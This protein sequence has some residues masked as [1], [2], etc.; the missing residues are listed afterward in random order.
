MQ[1]NINRKLLLKLVM[2]F[3]F[4]FGVY[5][6]FNKFNITNTKNNLD[7]K[8]VVNKSKNSIGYIVQKDVG[9]VANVFSWGFNRHIC[10]DDKSKIWWIFYYALDDT[11]K[12]G[13][14]VYKYSK[15]NGKTWSNQIK[16]SDLEKDAAD[17]TIDCSPPYIS[18]A[19]GDLG[20]STIYWKKGI[21]QNEKIHWT[22]SSVA[23]FD[24]RSYTHV[25]PSIVYWNGV[26][27]VSAHDQLESGIV[28]GHKRS[29]VTIAED[30]EGKK[31]KPEVKVFDGI[32]KKDQNTLAFT[33][34]AVAKN[35]LYALING[36]TAEMYISEYI[37]DNNWTEAKPIQ[38]FGYRGG[39]P[40]WT[41]VTDSQGTLHI[42]YPSAKDQDRVIKHAEFNGYS[43]KFEYVP[44]TS[45]IG[46]NQLA[47]SIDEKDNIYTVSGLDM[48]LSWLS[49]K[50]EREWKNNISIFKNTD[51]SIAFINM[52]QKFVDGKIGVGWV[53]GEYIN[54]T[55]LFTCL[56]RNNDNSLKT[57]D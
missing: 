37:G 27:V 42:I 25:I 44:N 23:L 16:L 49:K 10:F 53:E 34:I 54:P 48:N 20:Q 13:W 31:W 56:Q 5:L 35:N 30:S 15:N 47:A 12:P 4:L 41:T 28:G 32:I 46:L 29:Y 24:P 26:P 39:T 2:F 1:T 3:F 33:S 38:D 45:K 36:D 52:M 7:K 51:Q 21:M 8:V 17:F 9:E 19:Y 14:V 55:I 11:K 6:L 50:D 22:V 57:C 43:W 18:V 40:E